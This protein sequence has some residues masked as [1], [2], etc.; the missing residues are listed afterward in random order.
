MEK[1]NYSEYQILYLA[2]EFPQTQRKCSQVSRLTSPSASVTGVRLG[3]SFS[4]TRKD[5]RLDISV[6]DNVK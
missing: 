6:L 3:H 4:D 1:V 5:A 2:K